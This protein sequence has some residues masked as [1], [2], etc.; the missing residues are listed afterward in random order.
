MQGLKIT[1]IALTLALLAAT[2]SQALMCGAPIDW[3]DTQLAEVTLSKRD[4]IQQHAAYAYHGLPQAT[5]ETDKN[6]AIG[7]LTPID[8]KFTEAFQEVKS[9]SDHF[10]D[11][12]GK[13]EVGHVSISY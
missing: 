10:P 8:P 2:P 6:I 1:P 7:T 5:A 12:M 13:I 9:A 3:T 11:G 4:L